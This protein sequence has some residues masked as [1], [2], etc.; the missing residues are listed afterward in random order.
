MMLFDGIMVHRDQYLIY[1]NKMD[2]WPPLLWG[3]VCVL[4]GRKANIHFIRK[5]E[6]WMLGI[7]K[8]MITISPLLQVKS[9]GFKNIYSRLRR[10]K[11]SSL[12]VW[13]SLSMPVCIHLVH[14]LLFTACLYLSIPLW[15]ILPILHLA[16]I[17]MVSELH[18]RS[19]F[20]WWW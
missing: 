15:I 10:M 1:C 3:K 8:S 7:T 20:V 19:A 2:R 9:C 4:K 11:E 18:R 5:K 14:S 16:E 12:F 13:L 6:N 17:S